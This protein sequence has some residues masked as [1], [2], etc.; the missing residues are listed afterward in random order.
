MPAPRVNRF[1]QK[2]I[3]RTEII[4][5]SKFGGGEGL[6][7]GDETAGAVSYCETWQLAFLQVY[8]IMESNATEDIV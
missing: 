3:S 7:A 8:S 6:T 5:R 4:L 2:K 1:P